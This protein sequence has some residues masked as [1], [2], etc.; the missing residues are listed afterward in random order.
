MARYT[1]FALLLLL[2][3]ILCSSCSVFA[4]VVPTPPLYKVKVLEP[5]PNA[6]IPVGQQIQLKIQ[7]DAPQ[8]PQ[9]LEMF[10]E[11]IRTF[12]LPGNLPS[13]E[14]VY[15]VITKDITEGG[16]FTYQVVLDTTKPN[17]VPLTLG[18]YTLR[19]HQLVNSGTSD[20]TRFNLLDIPIT[21]G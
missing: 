14:I 2:V 5:K 21:I 1:H 13:Q 8:G 3:T 6:V 7:A 11:L 9:I 17:T 16:T 15:G 12:D 18:P 19:I 4:A 10:C 20:S